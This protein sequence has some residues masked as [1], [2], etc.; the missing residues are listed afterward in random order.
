[1]KLRTSDSCLQTKLIRYKKKEKNRPLNLFQ[2]VSDKITVMRII[3]CLF[4]FFSVPSYGASSSIQGKRVFIDTSVKSSEEVGL[5]YFI[6]NFFSLNSFAR[7][8]DKKEMEKKLRKWNP[9]IRSWKDVSFGEQIIIKQKNNVMEA[10][11]GYQFSNN[12]EDLPSDN[13]ISIQNQ[14]NNFGASYMH[15]LTPSIYLSGEFEFQQ[16]WSFTSATAEKTFDYSPTINY[17]LLFNYLTKKRWGASLGL[18]REGLTFLSVSDIENQSEGGIL[19][20]LEVASGT[21]YWSQL[22][23]TYR[24]SS[25]G[26]GVYYSGIFSKSIIGKKS[27]E[28]TSDTNELKGIKL[29]LSWKKYWLG[30]YWT[31]AYYEFRSFESLVEY[32]RATIGFNLGFTFW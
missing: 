27:Y 31:K 20:R 12:N 29:G 8:F 5:R 13:Q 17:S 23:L 10:W 1:M 4:L 11:A 25:E 16:Q 14:G 28:S 9:H 19:R 32:T 30:N 15:F 3:L 18:Q 7:P 21:V 26:R 2:N 6:D 24:T 22:H